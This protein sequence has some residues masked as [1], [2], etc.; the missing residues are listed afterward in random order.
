LHLLDC[1]DA[2]GGLVVIPAPSAVTPPSIESSS[3]NWNSPKTTLPPIVSA[4]VQNLDMVLAAW[5]MVRN[6]VS[7]RRP[8]I[9]RCTNKIQSAVMLRTLLTLMQPSLPKRI[10]P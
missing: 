4:S 3:T 6:A 5:N 7:S 9:V 8:V 10:A 2:N 1:L